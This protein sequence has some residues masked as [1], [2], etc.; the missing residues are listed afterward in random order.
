M[1]EFLPKDFD[2]T[3]QQLGAI[4]YQECE[5]AGFYNHTPA[6]VKQAMAK[7]GL[8]CVS[9]HYPMPQLQQSLDDILKFAG[10]LGLSYIICSSPMIHGTTPATGKNWVAALEAMDQDGWKWNFDQMNRIGALVQK[11]GIQFG[12]HN[13]FIEFHE[14]DGFL[15]YD[16]LLKETDPKLV[17]MEM[18]CGWVVIGG[19]KPEEYLT[20][21]PERYSMLHV[22][23][24]RLEGWKPGD[25]V[26]STEMGRGSI[27]YASIFTAAKKARIKHIFVEQEAFP[28]MPGMEALKADADWLKNFRS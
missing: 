16:L 15:P 27:D 28:D 19:H 25:E 23:E 26:V 10:E 22:K 5:A 11:E 21:Y 4:G 17:T 1:R 3:L 2:G 14:H 8:H 9:A 6:E 12:Y 7:A 18:D 20:R 24:F 13:H